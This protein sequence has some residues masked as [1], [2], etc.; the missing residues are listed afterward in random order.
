MLLDMQTMFSDDQEIRASATGTASEQ[1]GST[2]S[3][4]H[5]NLLP[6]GRPFT[7]KNTASANPQLKRDLGAG[8]PIPM[9]VQVTESFNNLTSLKVEL[10]VSNNKDFS[11]TGTGNVLRTVAEKTMLLADLT[12]GAR[13]LNRWLPEKT[14]LQF[15]RLYYT[16]VGTAPTAGK[17]MAGLTYGTNTNT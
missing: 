17:I 1:L 11:G 8:E 13:P 2:A 12:A 15:V 6:T 7:G 16:V 14:D 5:V 9:L 10:Q 4:N 3:T